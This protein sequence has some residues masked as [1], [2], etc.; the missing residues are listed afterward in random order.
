MDT[1]ANLLNFAI[2]LASA[3]LA[4][5]AAELV[6]LGRSRPPRLAHALRGA[7][8]LLAAGA[9]F[10][11]VQ[12]LRPTGGLLNLNGTA[13]FCAALPALAMATLAIL[14]S[15]MLERR[16]PVWMLASATALP[17]ATYVHLIAAAP[18]A[19]RMAQ[20]AGPAGI[21]IAVLM[22]SAALIGLTSRDGRLRYAAALRNGCALAVALLATLAA[23][24]AAGSAAA[25]IDGSAWLLMGALMAMGAL[26]ASVV[27]HAGNA[28]PSSVAAQAP[29]APDGLTGLPTRLQFEREVIAAAK[30]RGDR[31]LAVFFIDLDGLK[32]VNDRHGRDAGDRLLAQAGRRIRTLAQGQLAAARMGGDEFALLSGSIV[33]EDAA[34][35]LA[36]QIVAAMAEPYAL[37]GGEVRIGCSVGIA[38][39][40]GQGSATKLIARADAAMY[41]A[42]QAG[43]NRH[44][45]HVAGIEGTAGDDTDLLGELRHALAND[46][47]EL[48]FQPKID[49]RSGQITAAEALLRWQHPQRGTVL[50]DKFI[51]LAERSG[52]IEPIGDWVI[53][54][55]CKQAR[56]WRDKGL[57]MRVAIN[58]SA[59]QMR[60][61]D[62]ADR[63]ADALRRHR[64]HPSLLTC[65]ITESAAMEDTSATH[66]TFRRLGEMGAHVSIDDFGTGYS[67]LAYLRR[68]PAEELKIDRQFIM[69][70]DHSADAR[71]VVDAVM[72]L[73]HALG[74]KVVAEGVETPRQHEILCDLGCDEL[75]GYLFAKPMT[76]RALLLWAIE[77][78]AQTAFRGS[79]FVETRQVAPAPTREARRGQRQ[80]EP[81][82]TPQ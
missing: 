6:H 70:L 67:S 25:P 44:C 64:V 30:K 62:L 34:A 76:G 16:A 1:P 55:A 40:D 48:Y 12:M 7:A 2:L 69:D 43:G 24:P 20:T 35:R 41:A 14:F 22:L 27:R 21:G 59:H 23:Q 60:Q 42:K 54:A 80:S 71:A 74:L 61:D 39:Q 5:L 37:D 10:W 26:L 77:D 56:A 79:L 29:V 46:Q 65:E 11:P 36:T 51:P 66:E 58:L 73:A 47:F 75:Q 4:W 50:P 3:T 33:R 15:A 32:S 13:G 49:A 52:L 72:K 53:E 45:F 38:L 8:V 17:L 78:G 31:G 81:Q 19:L 28:L 68:L 63:I 9:L 57:R 18:A 82:S